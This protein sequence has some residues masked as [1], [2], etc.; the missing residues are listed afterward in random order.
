MMVGK[1][2]FAS[3]GEPEDERGM[4]LLTGGVV[5]GVATAL[6]VSQSTQKPEKSR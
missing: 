2:L 5:A 1:A 4:L 3:D 6:L